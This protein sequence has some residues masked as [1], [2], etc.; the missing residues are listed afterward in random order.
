ME[1]AGW[2]DGRSIGLHTPLAMAFNVNM[3]KFLM[4]LAHV[5]FYAAKTRAVSIAKQTRN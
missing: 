5:P 1:L 4:L 3:W 2:A